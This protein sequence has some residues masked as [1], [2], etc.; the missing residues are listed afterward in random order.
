MTWKTFLFLCVLV[1]WV[2]GPAWGAEEATEETPA[3][4][5]T[6]ASVQQ[7]AA[8]GEL[9]PLPDACE[10]ILNDPLKTD[11]AGCT[12]SYNCVHGG[13]VECSSNNIGTCISTGQRCGG[14]SCDGVTTWCPGACQHAF[15]CATFCHQTYGSTDGTC[16]EFGCCVC[17]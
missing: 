12:A 7:I 14:V 8:S 11:K 17:F 6:T 3:V 10:E 1:C 5:T 4:A 13:T 2:A 16:D 9:Q 15:N